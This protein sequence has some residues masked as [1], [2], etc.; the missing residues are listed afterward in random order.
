MKYRLPID[1]IGDMSLSLFLAQR[2][3]LKSSR[4]NGSTGILIAIIGITLSVIVMIVSISVM[5]G[6]RHEIRQKVIGFD[7]QMSIGVKTGADTDASVLIS[8]DDLKTTREILPSSASVS[9]SVRQPAIIK[10]PKNFSGSII[11]G[12][13]NN[14]DWSFLRSNLVEGIIPDYSS[15]STMYHIMVS[16]TLANTLEL[17]LG[18]KVDTY[19]LGNGAYRARRLKIAGIYDTHFSEYD[20][21]MVFGSLSMLQQ[22]ASVPDTCATIAEIN[23]LPDDETIDNLSAKLSKAYL[24]RLYA[25]STDR[26]YSIVNIHDTAALYFN[27]LALLDTNVKVIL[28]LMSLLTILTLISSLFILILRRVSMIGILKAIGAS[29]RLVRSTFILL[30]VRILARGLLFGNIIGIGFLYIQKTT[31]LIPLNPDSYYLDHVPVMIDWTSILLLNAGIIVLSFIVLLLPS[32]IVTT[33]P[34]S[35]A[36]NYE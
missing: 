12:V 20:R 24:D 6:F 4:N 13:D 35:K 25:G 15:D 3:S 31:R 11:K 27:W 33:I 19:F 2:L 26:V 16:R 34:P 30:A 5:M 18:Q 28:T 32:A 22:V 8:N 29:N 23:G 17:E 36:I 10:T 21:N 9:L 1:S 7:S 14:Y